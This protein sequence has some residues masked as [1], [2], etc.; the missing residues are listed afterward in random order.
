MV[1]PQGQERHQYRGTHVGDCKATFSDS[2]LNHLSP[3]IHFKAI[4]TSE[5]M[6]VGILTGEMKL[7]PRPDLVVG[8]LL[9]PVPP[10]THVRGRWQASFPWGSQH[11]GFAA[12]SASSAAPLFFFFR[13]LNK[14][15]IHC[16]LIC[17]KHQT[18]SLGDFGYS[19]GGK[20]AFSPMTLAVDLLPS[21]L[22]YEV[23]HGRGVRASFS[24]NGNVQY[25]QT[26]QVG[27]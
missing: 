7:N 2:I 27:F 9:L 4:V 15:A 23:I 26:I 24:R 25:G 21:G 13:V 8:S 22:L 6:L 17:T 10:S 11:A 12:K 3:P 19:V 1:W 20:G 14:G 18:Q 5:K 16:C